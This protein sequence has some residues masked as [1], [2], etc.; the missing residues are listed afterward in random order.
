MRID[1]AL[2]IDALR[3]LAKKRLPRLV[4]D[5]ID[6]GVENE[7]GLARNLRS[8][9]EL[10]LLPRYLVDVSQRDQSTTLLGRRYGAPFGIGPTGLAAFSRPGADGMLADAAVAANIPFVLSGA[11]TASIAAIAKRAPQHTWYQLYVSRDAEITAD[12]IRRARDAGIETLMLTVDVPVHAKRERDIRNGFM[13]PVKPTG[14][15]LLNMLGHPGWLFDVLRHGLPRF[16]NWAP[17]AG[18]GAGAKAVGEF[19]AAQI[20]FT[21]TWRD[22]EHIR[23]LWP[24]KLVI[25]GIMHPDDA[26]RALDAGVDGI[27]VS[28]H[29]GRQLDCAPAPVDVFPAIRAA[30]GGR[31]AL[32]LDSGV[33]RGAD[34]IKAKALGADFVFVGRA[35]LYGV[36]AG[37]QAGAQRAI[38]ILREEIDL[39]MAQ[40]G[41]AHM[42]DVGAHFLWPAPDRL[43]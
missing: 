41:A 3:L 21:Q 22:L 34:V 14:A 10:Q 15:A 6:G 26:Q 43:V 24:G 17:Y 8:F 11:G 42:D 5:Y 29:G 40:I 13:P 18:E 4:F 39:I 28:N 35:T 20:P 9:A 23:A 25:K 27:V 38:D 1:Q 12:L 36:A 16:E 2:N 32:M 31:L 19:F 33:R 7:A 37:A 30:V